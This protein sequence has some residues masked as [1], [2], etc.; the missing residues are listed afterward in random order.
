MKEKGG[1]F[2]CW[3]SSGDL[4]FFFKTKKNRLKATMLILTYSPE[5]DSH[6]PILPS[7]TLRVGTPPLRPHVTQT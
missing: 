3:L 1:V 7:A 4:A 6:R 5:N 2:D